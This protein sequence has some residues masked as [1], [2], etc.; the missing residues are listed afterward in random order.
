V[1]HHSAEEEAAVVVSDDW[2]VFADELSSCDSEKLRLPQRTFHFAITSP[3]TT[4]TMARS[5]TDSKESSESQQLFSVLVN[6]SF[7][8]VEV[9]VSDAEVLLAHY[10]AHHLAAVQGEITLQLSM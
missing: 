4:A 10:L 8:S 6:Q 1:S 2:K 7:G 3:H 5:C 9:V